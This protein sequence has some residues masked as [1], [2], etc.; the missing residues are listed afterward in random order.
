MRK[1]HKCELRS[2]LSTHFA[3]SIRISQ[4][5][6]RNRIFNCITRNHVRPQLHRIAVCKLWMYCRM[7][8]IIKKNWRGLFSTLV[9]PLIRFYYFYCY[10]R[11]C[12][13]Y[14]LL[15]TAVHE[16]NDQMILLTGRFGLFSFSAVHSRSIIANAHSFL[17]AL[18]HCALITTIIITIMNS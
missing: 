10:S 15:N 8:K 17:I 13:T 7:E 18:W 2:I 14:R 16:K 9:F 11:A 6:A 3:P 1:T 12:I 5:S 4:P